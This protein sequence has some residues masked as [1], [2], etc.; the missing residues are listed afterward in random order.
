T[1]SVGTIDDHPHRAWA[2]RQLQTALDVASLPA[3]LHFVLATGPNPA[4]DLVEF[5]EARGTDLVAMPTH[6]RSGLSRIS[7]G[8]VTERTVRLSPAACLVLR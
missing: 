4:L 7:F 2:E 6:G 8:S 5:C 1:G 3:S